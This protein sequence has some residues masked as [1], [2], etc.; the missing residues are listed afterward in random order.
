M[1]WDCERQAWR[2]FRIDRLARPGPAGS[3][4]SPREL[5]GGNPAA[6]VA[7]S[8]FDVPVRHQARVTVH[9]PAAQVTQLLGGTV[10]PIDAQTCEYRAGDDHRDWRAVRILM[11]GVEVEVHEPPEL[12]ERMGELS[13]RMARA[14][15]G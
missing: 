12:V 1:A 2:T 15:G 13:D 6:F 5:P 8:R 3:R 4:F 9:A 10:V 7:S 14:V 11:L